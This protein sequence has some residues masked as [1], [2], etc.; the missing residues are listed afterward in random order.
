MLPRRSSV[1]LARLTNR[2]VESVTPSSK[3]VVVW[4]DDPRGFGL[5]VTPKGRRV[6]FFWYRTASHVQRRYTIGEYSTA[7]RTEQART[8]AK[9]L[10]A[11]VAMGEDP[12]HQRQQARAMR[13]RDTVR[14]WFDAY[15]VAV[16]HLRSVGEIARIFERDILPVIGDRRIEE[17]ARSDVNQLLDRV[18]RRSVSMAGGVR[19]VLSAFYTWA[20]PRL[21]S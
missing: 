3:D 6:F 8:I 17:V 9:Q 20:L 14:E 15:K 2:S 16:A 1:T 7:L 4:D 10:R 19:R 21:P 12:S 5:K 18:A 13:G 11:R